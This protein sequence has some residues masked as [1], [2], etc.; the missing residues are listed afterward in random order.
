MDSRERYVENGGEGL[1]FHIMYF[2]L[3]GIMN[4]NLNRMSMWMRDKGGLKLKTQ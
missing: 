1:T 3:I 4:K 2:K